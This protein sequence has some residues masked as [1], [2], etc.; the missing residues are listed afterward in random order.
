MLN[1]SLATL[2]FDL[3][4]LNDGFLLLAI[5]TKVNGPVF[6]EGFYRGAIDVDAKRELAIF[7]VKG[8]DGWVV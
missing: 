8:R 5:V 6:S 7:C 1:L 4:G 2:G 3:D